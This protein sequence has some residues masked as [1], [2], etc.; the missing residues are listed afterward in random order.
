M[1][2]RRRAGQTLGP[3]LKPYTHL[4]I[5]YTDPALDDVLVGWLH[6]MENRRAEMEL[7]ASR[8]YG[9]QE[10]IHSEGR[11][12]GLDEGIRRLLDRLHG[13]ANT[14]PTEFGGLK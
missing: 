8:S 11:A 13:F 10:S 3:R 2:D 7:R 12:R 5:D 6:D 14:L 4:D 1:Q 9:S